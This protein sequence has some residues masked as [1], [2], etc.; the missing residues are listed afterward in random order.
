MM[1]KERMR[2]VEFFSRGYSLETDRLILRRINKSDAQDMYEYSR[3]EEVTRYLLW[4]PFTSLDVS[5]AYI[6]TLGKS[7]RTGKFFDFAV[8]V[9]DEKKMIGTCGFTSVS[10]KDGAAE[11]GFV[12]NPAYHQKGYGYEAA[13]AVLRLGFMHFGFNRI[14]ARCMR[15]NESSRALMKKLGMEYEGC[16][17]QRMFVKGVYRDIETCS[18]LKSEFVEKYSDGAANIVKPALTSILMGN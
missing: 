8:I 18:I 4:K 11:I 2:P 14:E 13:T 1:M 10:E 9:K 3:L 17:R 7:Y 16:A 6:A 5:R 12:L 15:G